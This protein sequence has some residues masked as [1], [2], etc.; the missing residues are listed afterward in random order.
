MVNFV[1]KKGPNKFDLAM[2][3]FS[4]QPGSNKQR[5]RVVFENENGKKVFRYSESNLLGR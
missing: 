2:S 4:F 1:L 5:N 3:F